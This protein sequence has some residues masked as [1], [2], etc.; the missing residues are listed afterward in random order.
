MFCALV[1][2]NTEVRCNSYPVKVSGL[3]VYYD[4]AQEVVLVDGLDV[5]GQRELRGAGVA[6]HKN[7][8]SGKAIVVGVVTVV[9]S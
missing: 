5:V 7:G 8:D 2:L 3:H 4:L 9:C 1:T 6:Y